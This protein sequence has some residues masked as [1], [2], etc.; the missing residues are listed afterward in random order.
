MWCFHGYCLTHLITQL[1]IMSVLNIKNM[2]P[3]HSKETLKVKVYEL[4]CT[5]TMVV[6]RSRLMQFLSLQMHVIQVGVA[7]VMD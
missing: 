1:V 7:L 5:C 4:E 6:K 2:C 3:S